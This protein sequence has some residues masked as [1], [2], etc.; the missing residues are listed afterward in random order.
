MVMIDFTKGLE[1]CFDIYPYIQC[2]GDQKPLVSLLQGAEKEDF[3]QQIKSLCKIIVDDSL[4]GRDF[5]DWC[6]S[7]KSVFKMLMYPFT[8]RWLLSL[9]RRGLL[10]DFMP[11]TKILK[12]LNMVYCESHKDTF[13]YYLNKKVQE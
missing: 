12:F 10:P 2:K 11:G 6:E 9:W 5:E 4:L 1:R 7:R 3:Y 13:V 8:N